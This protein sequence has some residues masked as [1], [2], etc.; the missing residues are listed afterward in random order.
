MPRPLSRRTV[1]RGAGGITVGLPFLSAML[2]PLRSH[3]DTPVQKR[4]IVFF[5]PNGTI[6]DAWRPTGGERDF[7]LSPILSPLERHRD[8]LLILD[9]I[10]MRSALEH[11]GGSN[12]HDAG[13]GHSLTPWPLIEG[14]SGVGEFGHL[15]DGSAGG[16]SF[17]QYVA[18]RLGADHPFSS[19]VWGV[20]C[21]IAQAIPSRISWKAPFESVR[22]MQEPGSAFDRVFGTGVTD[23]TSL[24]TARAQRLMVVDAVLADYQRLHARVGSEDRA[25]LDAHLESLYELERTVERLDLGSCDVP[26]RIDSDDLA[27][28]GEANLAML[29]AAAT[30]DLAPVLVHQWGSGQSARTFTELGQTENHHALS[31]APLTDADAVAQ[32]TAINTWYAQRFADLLDRLQSTEAGDGSSVLDHSVVLWCN[33]LGNGYTHEAAN[34]PYVVAGRCGGALDTGRFL[35]FSY[36]GHG[37]LFAGLGQALGLETATFGMPEVFGSPLTELLA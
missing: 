15:W 11:P 33:E 29:A 23:T 36:R 30:C 9:G 21:D 37:D 27:Q 2:R 16:Q 7:T 31:H 12:G 34:I 19:L 22:P 10:D 8:A 6:P 14:E 3:A 32:L 18:E 13:T 4:L 24:E 5:T 26:D 25:R 20:Q 17:D 1:L 28:I 35:S